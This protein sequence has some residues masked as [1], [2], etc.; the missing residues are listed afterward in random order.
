MCTRNRDTGGQST[1]TKRNAHPL[2]FQA[3]QTNTI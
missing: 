1:A 3:Q 2:N